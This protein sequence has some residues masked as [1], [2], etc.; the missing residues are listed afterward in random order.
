M[1]NHSP[2]KINHGLN[3]HYTSWAH[4]LALMGNHFKH[5]LMKQMS[6][7]Q[8]YWTLGYNPF[9]VS[10]I[11]GIGYNNPMPHSRF[12]GTSCGG[13]MVGFIGN[14]DDTPYVDLKAK[15]QWNST[16]YWVTP[17]A[18]LCMALAELLPE[19]VDPRTK[20]GSSQVG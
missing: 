8:I 6:W 2:Q 10:F 3:G 19:E 4:A 7:N 15:A 5:P 16:E 18:N 9:N 1:P 14:T 20:L 12:L 11:S 17:Q 13:F